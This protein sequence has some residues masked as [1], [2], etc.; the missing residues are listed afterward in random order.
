LLGGIFLCFF[1][2]HMMY[3]FHFSCVLSC[4]F[5]FFPFS[6]IRWVFSF[7]SYVQDFSFL[8]LCI[9]FSYII[10]VGICPNHRWDVSQRCVCSAI[11]YI[12]S[13]FWWINREVSVIQNR[14]H[15]TIFISLVRIAV[16]KNQKTSLSSIHH[17]YY[18]YV[19]ISSCF[20]SDFE[21]LRFIF[22]SNE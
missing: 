1:F 17:I 4:T 3:M 12:V 9:I 6:H 15:L 11:L 2:I 8:Y 19:L 20:Y 14:S 21:Q 13:V 18:R 7:L 16:W 22:T 5:D 10:P